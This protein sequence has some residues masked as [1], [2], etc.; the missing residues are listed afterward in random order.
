MNKNKQITA[1]LVT[2]AMVIM[3][4]IM[5]LRNTINAIITNNQFFGNIP[6]YE[7]GWMHGC[8]DTISKITGE[9]I[10]NHS[11]NTS[12]FMTGYE[13]GVEKCTKDLILQKSI[14]IYNCQP[15]APGCIGIPYCY[16]VK[17]NYTGASPCYYPDS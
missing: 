7:S 17:G 16:D 3:T 8:N 15:N 11:K 4:T 14:Q 13:V 5:M 2:A 9:S 10:F 6:P 1:A 12:D